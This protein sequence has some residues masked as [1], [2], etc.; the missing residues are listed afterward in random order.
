MMN[1]VANNYIA[2]TTYNLHGLNQ[3]RSFLEH[4]CDTRDIIFVQEH[5]LAPFNLTQLDS[6]CPNFQCLATSAM[7]DVVCC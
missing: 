4:Q 3:G 2:T 6:I 1:E 5:W 7:S